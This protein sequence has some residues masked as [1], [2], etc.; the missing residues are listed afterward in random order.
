MI[1]LGVVP[2]TSMQV[3]SSRL[4]LIPITVSGLKGGPGVHIGSDVLEDRWGSDAPLR[5]RGSLVGVIPQ[6]ILP[7]NHGAATQNTLRFAPWLAPGAH[8]A[9]GTLFSPRGSMVQASP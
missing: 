4:G 1:V 8:G 7:M 9:H 6:A 2:P 3:V 5:G